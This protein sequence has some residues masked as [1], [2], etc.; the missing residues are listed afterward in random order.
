VVAEGGK[1]C[2]VLRI[3]YIRIEEEASDFGLGL[4]VDVM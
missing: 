3:A 4:L 1:G 2:E